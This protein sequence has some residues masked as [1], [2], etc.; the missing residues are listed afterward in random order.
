MNILLKIKRFIYRKE[1]QYCKDILEL[2][3]TIIRASGGIG[4]AQVE[5]AKLQD[6]AVKGLE[7]EHPD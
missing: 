2:T 7:H 5:P 1:I 6:G 4:N 3:Y